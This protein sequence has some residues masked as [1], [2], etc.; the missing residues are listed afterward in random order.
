MVSSKLIFVFSLGGLCAAFVLPFSSNLVN[1]S[2]SLGSLE[3]TNG[4]AKRYRLERCPP[5]ATGL[6]NRA[7]VNVATW[8]FISLYAMR[9]TPRD[10]GD[11]RA[12]QSSFV[13]LNINERARGIIASRYEGVLREAQQP[14]GGFATLE[15]A[16][17]NWPMCLHRENLAIDTNAATHRLYLVSFAG[18]SG[19]LDSCG[20]GDM[21]AD[22]L[23]LWLSV[24]IFSKLTRPLAPGF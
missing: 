18:E 8:C 5:E 16:P 20:I 13:G 9:Q 19:P 14:H 7:L 11:E 3:A 21:Y 12:L 10:E 15:C 1:T 23:I 24:L 6:V 22:A 17:E 4:L 2:S